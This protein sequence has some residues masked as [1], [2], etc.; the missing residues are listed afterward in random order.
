MAADGRGTLRIHVPFIATQDLDPESG[1][2]LVRM[3]KAAPAVLVD[4]RPADA[5]P[6]AAQR[7]RLELPLDP[8]E[9][10]VEVM[11]RQT[12]ETV[13]VRI[14]AGETAELFVGYRRDPHSGDDRLHVGS[15]DHVRQAI[16]PA[17]SPGLAGGLRWGCGT[18]FPV[19]IAA[20]VAGVLLRDRIGWSAGAVTIA[21]LGGTTLIAL[22]AALVAGAVRRGPREDPAA[23]APEPLTLPATVDGPVL[24]LPAA[25]A[26]PE[27]TGIL[28][29][30]RVRP[31]TM[32]MIGFDK[33]LRDTLGLRRYEFFRNELADWVDAPAVHLDGRPLGSAWGTWWI[34]S[35]PG[36]R[37]LRVS[38]GGIRDPRNAGPAGPAL[39]AVTEVT[40]PAT[41]TAEVTAWFNFLDLVNERE[42]THPHV[43]SRWQRI[44]RSQD[45]YRPAAEQAAAEPGVE[46]TLGAER[47]R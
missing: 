8:G 25:A 12:Y 5:H 45:R 29:R 35:P 6:E 27:G 7:D 36:T 33:R 17:G 22:I 38:V 39:E 13:A 15:E 30:V 23:T 37:R 18:W 41:G 44:L 34:A 4:G 21:I 2:A 14:R 19:L 1:P 47:P 32:H 9:H 46:F 42:R 28:L 10:R 26:P 16:A 20:A 3:S 43:V 40:V 24:V 11:A 31:R